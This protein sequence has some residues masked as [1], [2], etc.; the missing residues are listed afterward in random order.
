[1]LK[2]SALM[3]ET[4]EMQ[5]DVF[6]EAINPF[7]P[8]GYRLAYGLVRNRDEADD[9]MQEATLNAWKHRHSLR[10]GSPVRP[11]FLAIV[12]NQCRQA[13]RTRWWSVIRR[14]DL[15]SAVRQEDESDRDTV[16]SLRRGLLTLKDRD[17]LVL[18]LRYYVDLSFDDVA[19][20]L[21]ISPQTARVRT[22]R[23]L[24]RLKPII[25]VPG[26]LSHE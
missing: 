19:A 1:M 24:A 22:H 21:H 17:R 11:W 18:V 15:A 3:A 14:P 13:V 8:I 5:S 16:E 26:D 10:V 12:A 25:D 9:I 23:A 2:A 7:L 4:G 6:M 20:V